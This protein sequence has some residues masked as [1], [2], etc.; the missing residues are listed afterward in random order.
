MPTNDLLNRGSI[1]GG[2]TAS[3]VG[4]Y[5][6]VTIE[7]YETSLNVGIWKLNEYFQETP[8]EIGGLLGATDSRRTGYSYTWELDLILD[9]RNPADILLRA[10]DPFEIVFNY[11][12]ITLSGMVGV[13]GSTPVD[14][15]ESIQDRFYWSPLN[16]LDSCVLILDSVTKKQMGVHVTGH[17]TGHVFL[18]PE[19]GTLNDT[20]TLIGAYNYYL[21]NQ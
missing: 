11:G 12:D 19:Q 14:G 15:G 5:L 13:N 1:S 16:K 6:D 20:T 21:E 3:S 9:L 10:I 18:S 2:G 4:G 8:L 7:D 17:A